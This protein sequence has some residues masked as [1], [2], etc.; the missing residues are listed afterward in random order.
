[1]Q[2]WRVAE[3]WEVDWGYQGNTGTKVW[4]RNPSSIRKAARE[5]HWTS[6]GHLRLFGVPT[7]TYRKD[8]W[9]LDWQRRSEHGRKVWGRNPSS[10]MPNARE[11]HW[12]DY[13]TVQLSG[14]PWKPVTPKKSRWINCN[15]YW[16]LSRRGMTE[17][18]I[19]IA[20][21]HGLFKGKKGRFVW[22]HQLV[23]ARKYGAIPPGSV[24]RHVNGV[25]TDNREQNLV[26]GTSREN[27]MD[28]DSAR[29]MAMYWREKYETLLASV[30]DLPRSER[31]QMGLVDIVE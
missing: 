9:E 25:K 13:H 6:T 24:V 11:W 7:P 18:E 29:R 15:G 2:A 5:W 14:A 10:K 26:L 3:T 12:V 19:S 16:N 17:E 4:A 30:K 1:M 22:E 23:A 21:R 28:H 8:S 31:G 20:T 27:T